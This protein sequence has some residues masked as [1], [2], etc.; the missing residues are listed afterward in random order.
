MLASGG[1]PG[2]IAAAKGFEVMDT[3]AADALVERLVAGHPV[4]FERLKSGDPKVIGFFVGQAMKVSGGKADGK[5]ITALL[6]SRAGL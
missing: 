6:R 1:D 5:A 4:E 2:A 3:G